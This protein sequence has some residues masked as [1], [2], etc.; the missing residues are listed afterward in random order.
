MREEAGARPEVGAAVAGGRG[1]P[2][3]LAV[4]SPHRLGS[5]TLSV[6]TAV[7]VVAQAGAPSEAPDSRQEQGRTPWR[8]GVRGAAAS[9]GPAGRCRPRRCA[10]GP[11]GPSPWELPF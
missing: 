10:C 5:A 1:V 9:A 7:T 3:G 11:C 8:R 4:L 6:I 2:P